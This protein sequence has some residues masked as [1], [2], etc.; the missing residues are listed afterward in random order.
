MV[1]NNL[2]AKLIANICWFPKTILPVI[3]FSFTYRYR[4]L[5]GLSIDSITHMPPTVTTGGQ[6]TLKDPP[7]LVL[8]SVN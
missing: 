7:S 5:R 8:G 6:I 4:V 2:L 3:S 1:G